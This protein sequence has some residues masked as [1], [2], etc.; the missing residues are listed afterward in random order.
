MTDDAP[1]RLE[2]AER[3]IADLERDNARL[4]RQLAEARQ[5][6][7]MARIASIAVL[8]ALDL[9]DILD[10]LLQCIEPM[11]PF[12]TACVLLLDDQGRASMQAGVGF[13]EAIQPGE[14]VFDVAARPHLDAC[15][16]R[17]S[18]VRIADTT[19]D[20]GWQHGVDVSASTRSWLGVPLVARGRVLG[21]FGL[22]KREPDFFTDG[23]VRLAEGLAAHAALAVANALRQRPRSP[24]SSSQTVPSGSSGT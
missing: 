5:L 12:D 9:Q 21:L 19:V 3:R 1:G 11:I 7:D 13:D 18:S 6:E 16:R 4:L 14:V 23:H 15:V 17:M 10:T 2:A 8:E 24:T 20:P 22:D